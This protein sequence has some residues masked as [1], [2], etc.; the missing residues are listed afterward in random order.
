MHRAMEQGH[1]TASR[2]RPT[3]GQYLQG[4][5]DLKSCSE[6]SRIYCLTWPCYK[7]TVKSQN[8][9]MHAFVNQLLIPR[10]GELID[11]EQ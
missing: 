9:Y 2:P 5:S 4:L 7:Y 6:E 10:A 3:D 11:A 8:M 1:G